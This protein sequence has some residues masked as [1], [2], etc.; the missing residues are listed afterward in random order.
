MDLNSL[1]LAALSIDD[2]SN[3]YEAVRLALAQKI[4][5][6]KRKL[7]EQLS[8]LSASQGANKT[9]PGGRRKGPRRTRRPYPPV[10]PKFRNPADPSETWTGR[11]KQ[12]RWL[13]S[14]LKAGREAEDFLISQKRKARTAKRAQLRET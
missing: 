8:K 7:E 3:L 14:Q 4:E 6:E 2:L 10:R 5:E 13:V 1:D 9:G 12:P 11:G